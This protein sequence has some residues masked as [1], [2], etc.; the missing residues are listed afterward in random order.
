MSKS[1]TTRL[2]QI[3]IEYWR[4]YLDKIAAAVSPLT[5]DEFWWRANRSSN[6]VGN[7]LLHLYGNLGQW[8][9]E[10]LGGL[11]TQRRRS[12]EFAAG[13]D[14]ELPRIAKLQALERLRERVA[15]CI[16]VT[17]GLPAAELDRVRRIQKYELDGWKALLHTVE[18]M[19]YHTGQIV[20][21]AKQLR[22]ETGLDFYPQHRGE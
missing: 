12:E 5:E 13:L 1:A 16:E 15:Q 8:V 3:A 11:R 17:T 4:E 9:L 2:Q 20:Q 19:A 22:P 18:H 21:L 14:G 7:L 6:S 10:G